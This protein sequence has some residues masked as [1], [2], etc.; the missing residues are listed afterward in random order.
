MPYGRVLI[1]DDVETNLYVAKGLL[2]PYELSIDTAMSGFETIDKVKAGSVYDIIFMDHMMPKMDGLETTKNLRAMG[3][4]LPIIALTANAVAGQAEMFLSNGF[5]DFISKPI[6]MR[7]LNALLNRLIRDKQPPEVLQAA[8]SNQ[9]S[10]AA[11]KIS[12]PVLDSDLARTF[13]RD[14]ERAVRVLNTI[15]EKSGAFEDD[16]IQL[17]TITTHAMK[18]ALA[19]IGET[20]LSDF[21]RKLETAGRERDLNA[22]SAETPV[23]LNDLQTVIKK[24]APPEE[25]DS[26]KTESDDIGFLQEKLLLFRA[27]C[28]VYDKKAA[29]DVIVELKKK[30]WSR[31]IKELLNTLTEHLLHSDFEEAANIAR[32][33]DFDSAS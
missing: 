22:I 12:P 23:F 31:Q 8:Q 17:Y 28:V 13:I 29:K 14:A 9:N 32:D 2:A 3:Y 21:A 18:S 4:T 15:H 20:E 6:D 33:F 27:A 11:E 16:D 24:I 30:S 5:N 25:D 1:V 7:Q 26:G 19:N 10:H